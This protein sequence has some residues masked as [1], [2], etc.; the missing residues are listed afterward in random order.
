MARN[1]ERTPWLDATE[2]AAWLA[3]IETVGDLQYAL[4]NDLKEAVAMSTGDYQVLVYLSESPERSMRMCDLAARLNLTPSGLTR[5][6]DGL[7]R[8]GSV[9]RRQSPDDRRVQLAELTADGY[10]RLVEAAPHHVESV[11]RRFIDRL[12]R[13][14]LVSLAAAFTSIQKGLIEV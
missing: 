5:R 3:F 8:E 9:R 6:L 1:R 2:M 7:V 13:A 4:D 12:T 10:R 14:Q 11:R